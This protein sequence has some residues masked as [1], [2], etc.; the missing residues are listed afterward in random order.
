M[1]SRRATKRR[2]PR[3]RPARGSRSSPFTKIWSAT[4][5]GPCSVLFG[6]V[7]CVLLIACLNIANLILTRAMARARE[8]GIRTALGASRGRIVRQLVT[9]SV[10]LGLTGGTV[11][12]LLA[13]WLANVLVARA[14]GAEQILPSGRVPLDPTVFLFAFA[15]A[16]ITGVAAGLVP[17]LRGSR[18]DVTSDLKDAARSSTPGRVH[19]R[20]RDILIG[21]EVALS[22]VLL[23][24]AGLLVHSFIRL[25]QVHPGVRVDNVL[26]MGTT[27]AGPKYR[28]AA[29][30]SVAIGALGDRLRTVPGV[31]SAGMVSCPPVSGSCNVLFFYIEGKPY[32]PGK[33]FAALERSADPGYFGAA[34]IP[35]VRGR[36]FTR[37]DGVGFDPKNPKPGQVV[38]SESMARQFFPGEDPLGKRIFFDFEMQREKNEGLPAPRYE[39]IGIVG[40]VLPMLHERI[41]PTLYR[42]MLDV[43]MRGFSIFLHTSLEPHSVVASA[44]AAVRELD[45]GLAVFQVRTMEDL[46]GQSTA[47]RRFN[48]LLIVAFA[49]LAML[50][51]AVGLFGMVSYAVSQRTTEIGLRMALG[52]TNSDV[53]RLMLLQGLKPTIVGML[54]GLVIAA[55]S[56]RVAS[57]LLFNVTPTDPLTFALVPPILLTLATLACY[58][59]ARRAT[60]LDPVVALRAE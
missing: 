57:G 18:A 44:R 49:V 14:P 11:G 54:I 12:A 53:R 47:D 34:G 48:V 43:A 56:T 45:P 60:R 21:A 41:T 6:A 1:A 35:L 10:V 16:L 24:L 39:V 19:G 31:N 33:F 42:P 27:L 59:P 5:A 38:I 40:D 29:T 52:A 26:T 23:M 20:F 46:L 32:V 4:F 58:L 15:I 37:D 28:D 30:R 7:L 13:L 2:T 36:T 25:Y 55:F 9:E 51:A 17:A 50:L 3:R 8:I 22:L